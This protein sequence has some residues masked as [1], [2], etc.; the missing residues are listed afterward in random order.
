MIRSL[1]KRGV[2]LIGTTKKLSDQE[3][4]FVKFFRSL[5]K[6]SLPLMKNVLTSLVK[7]VWLPNC[8]LTV[9]IHQWIDKTTISIQ[10]VW[11][12]Q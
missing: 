8:L 12:F 2:L 1:E 3:G 11:Q 10:H 6:A 4:G 5:V 7:N 9:L